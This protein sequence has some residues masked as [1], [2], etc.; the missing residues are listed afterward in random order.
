MVQKLIQPQYAIKNAITSQN[1]HS[2]F[3]PII[4]PQTQNF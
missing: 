1:P 4:Y 2:I 3:E